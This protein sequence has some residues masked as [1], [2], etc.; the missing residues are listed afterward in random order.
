VVKVQFTGL[1][2]RCLR[3]IFETANLITK[4][5]LNRK[6]QGDLTVEVDVGNNSDNHTLSI[7]NN[8][9]DLPSFFTAENAKSIYFSNQDTLDKITSQN[10]FYDTL[11]NHFKKYFKSLRFFFDEYQALNVSLGS[12]N[13]IEKSQEKLEI[14]NRYREFLIT[15]KEGVNNILCNSLRE[16]FTVDFEFISGELDADHTDLNF[17]NPQV[18]LKI[19]SQTELKLYFNEAKLKLTSIAV[20]F[21]LIKLEEAGE[22]KKNKFKLLV[23][24]DF[25]TSL[26]MANRHF[27]IEYVF[28]AFSKY[29]II[30]FT[31]NLQ[32]NNI[33]I[34]W[35]KNKN[36]I[37][38][39]DCKNIYL[40]LNEDEHE[41]ILYDYNSNYLEEA[42]ERLAQNELQICGNLVRKE[43][44]RILHEL[45]KIYQIGGK[46]ECN[47]II[48][49][50]NGNHPI[51]INQRE[52]LKSTLATVKHCKAMLYDINR[53]AE[54][55]KTCLNEIPTEAINYDK[56]MQ[57]ILRQ[58]LF[59]R[60]IIMNTSSHDN[61]DTEV[62]RKEYA[63][64]ISVIEELKNKL[65]AIRR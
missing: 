62:Y 55:I 29:Q 57:R 28:S 46:E 38:K 8:N 45:E 58:A 40:R 4:K 6:T 20:F 15:L 52:M 22:I 27:I 25:L 1:Y 12:G 65:E 47:S 39:W 30:I 7:P 24:D 3:L 49:L 21:T 33:I 53:N 34:D 43:F 64:C 17:S 10:D 54:Q 35:I 41:S 16:D 11:N 37:N 36:Q 51:Y 44:E 26:D 42:R 2:T 61:P 5:F 23:L 60:K 56:E 18:L 9:V 19:N 32:F 13:H 50:I 63:G 14:D 59:Y 48:E 31:H